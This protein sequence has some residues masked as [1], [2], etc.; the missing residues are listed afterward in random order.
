M[1]R[2]DGEAK[3]REEFLCLMLKAQLQVSCGVASNLKK[4][5][6]EK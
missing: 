3:G 6:W 4:E 2:G 1:V 5:F